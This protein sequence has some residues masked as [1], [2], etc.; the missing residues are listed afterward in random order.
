MERGPRAAVARA[1][2]CR[3]PPRRAAIRSGA[4]SRGRET[5]DRS[6]RCARRAPRR[7]RT[8]RKSCTAAGADGAPRSCRSVRPVSDEI[9][10]ASGTCGSTSVSN[11]STISK[12]HTLAAPISQIC[13]VPGRKPG[14]LEV[15]DD[16]RRV[17]E[18]E[19][20]AERSREPDGV[21]APREPRV[22]L[23]DLGEERAR[24]R[25]RRLAQ[26]EEPARRLLGDDRSAPLL[27]E[28]HEAVGGVQPQLHAREPRRTYVRSPLAALPTHFRAGD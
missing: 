10:A 11:R 22:G 25:D 13:D 28:L 27:D 17:F 4:R 24:E 3:R 18:Q 21:A 6:A 12:P 9:D 16:V 1:A 15:D 23:D 14:R 26:R 2:P 8:R 19:V 7:R 20:G 5:R